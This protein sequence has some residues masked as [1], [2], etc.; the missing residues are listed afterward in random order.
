MGTVVAAQSYEEAEGKAAAVK[1]EAEA[2]LFARMKEA[3]GLLFLKQKEAEG[4]EVLYNAQA[5]GLGKLKEMFGNDNESLLKYIM[6][7]ENQLTKLAEINSNAIKGLNPKITIWN[8]SNASNRP[9][10]VQ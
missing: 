1:I 2:A 3:E 8:T 9:H 5:K 6:I 10:S 7:R 4:I